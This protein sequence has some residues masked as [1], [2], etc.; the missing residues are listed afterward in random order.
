M[1]VIE[2][3][4]KEYQLT[5]PRPAVVYN[6]A[7]F[8]ELNAAKVDCIRR[9][10]I[11]GDKPLLGITLGEKDGQFRAPFSAPFAMFDFNREHGAAVMLEA[12]AMLREHFPGAMFT[13]PPA[14]YAP[15][16]IAKTQLSMLAA[17]AELHSSE[18]NYHLDL[19]QSF[20]EGMSSAARNKL[21]QAA[22][23]GLTMETC[24]LPRAYEVIRRNRENRGY[25]LAMRLEQV[26][27]TTGKGGPVR[28]DFFV[29]TDGT[30]DVAA[31]IIYRVTPD[32]AQV[33]YWGD[34]CCPNAV[35]LLARDVARYYAAAGFRFLDIGPSGADGMPNLGLSDFKDSIGCITTPKPV[36]LL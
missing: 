35:N 31:A 25:D 14:I 24:D 5:F 16:M 23:L 15:S 13:L 8:T 11:C 33:I 1:K 9:I 7:A 18:W 17:G 26:A 19:S 4:A 32:V 2:V 36:L 27:A 22:R 12:S 3:S 28:A 29:M 20:E 21:R 34:D 30:A 6:S 10:I